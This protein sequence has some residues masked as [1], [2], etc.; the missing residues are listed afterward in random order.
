ME[1][2]LMAVGFILEHVKPAH[3][4]TVFCWNWV[5]DFWNESGKRCEKWW[6]RAV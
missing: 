2:P 5:S 3:N 6:P 4:L 1:L